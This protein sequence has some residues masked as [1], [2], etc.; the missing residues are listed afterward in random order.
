M[1]T[2]IVAAVLGKYFAVLDNKASK[3]VT[4]QVV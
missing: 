3:P 1:C 2:E 4:G